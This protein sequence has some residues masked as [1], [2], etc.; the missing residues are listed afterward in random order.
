MIK[1]KIFI[2]SS[3]E[4]LWIAQYVKDLLQQKNFEVTIW[5]ESLWD[6]SVFKINN[7]YLSDLLKATLKYDYGI[8][9]GTRD[10]KVEYR[11]NIVMSPRDNVIFELG[12][13]LG[14][15]GTSKCA[16]LLELNVNLLS[17]LK[18]LTLTF[19]DRN[20][21]KSISDAVDQISKM[22]E[23]SSDEE[24]NLFPSTTL[25]TTYFENLI[26]PTCKYLIEN[27]GLSKNEDEKFEKV[28]LKILI[29]SSINADINLQSHLIKTNYKTILK[30]IQKL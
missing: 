15:L 11:G 8:L 25:A 20:D 29:P 13:F 3:T 18:G 21:K 26:Y 24:L 4:E 19:F 14:R 2:G 16:F 22:F 9:I 23:N 28:K 30:K 7:N 5:N 12:L 17:D 27:N 6:S 1:K 10:D